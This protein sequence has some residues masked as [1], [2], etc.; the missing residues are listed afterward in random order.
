[1]KA[2]CIS[3]D[4][5]TLADHQQSRAAAFETGYPLTVGGVYP[6]VGITLAERALYFLV[7]DDW[8]GPCFAPAGLFELFSDEVPAGWKFA[9]EPGIRASGRELWSEPGVAT[10]GYPELVDDPEYVAQLVELLPAAVKVFEAQI[11]AA[12][13]SN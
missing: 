7:R 8:G 2:T 5:K 3:N 10:W 1:M 12:L 13:E 4:P 6:V 11:D 9:L